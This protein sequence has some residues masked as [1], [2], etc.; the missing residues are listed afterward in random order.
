MRFGRKITELE[1][2][3]HQAVKQ[4]TICNSIYT[5]YCSEILFPYKL[6]TCAERSC[7]NRRVFKAVT[8]SSVEKQVSAEADGTADKEAMEV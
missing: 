3:T 8:G 4:H 6:Y 2:K 1:W 7:W 5:F